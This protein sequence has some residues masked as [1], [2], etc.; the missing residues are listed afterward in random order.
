MRKERDFIKS[1]VDVAPVLVCVLDKDGSIVRFNR[2]CEQVTGFTSQE[3][4]GR[5]VWEG[6]L[7]PEETDFVREIFADIL[8]GNVPSQFENDWVTKDGSRRRIQWYNSAMFY[9]QG[10][11]KHIIGTGIDITERKAL[12]CQLLQVQK[13]EAVGQLAAGIAH[14]INTPTQ[15][16]SDNTHFSSTDFGILLSFSLHASK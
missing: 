16:V 12:Q 6:L 7:T 9:S 13:L 15:Y 4:V 14:E 2:A 8:K 10:K 3:V 11:V 1:V 5:L